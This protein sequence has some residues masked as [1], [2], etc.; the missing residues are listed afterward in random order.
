MRKTKPPPNPDL[1]AIPTRDAVRTPLFW[2]LYEHHK[3]LAENWRGHRVKWPAVC[4]WAAAHGVCDQHGNAIL[5]GTVKKTWARV[6]A[7]VEHEK[8]EREARQRPAHLRSPAVNQAPAIAVA[9][10]NPSNRSQPAPA[11]EMA[12]AEERVAALNAYIRQRSG[13]S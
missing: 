13:R 10:V 11:Q 7:L 5:P 9:V 2:L 12:S 6:C 3:A 8:A 4:A 1:P